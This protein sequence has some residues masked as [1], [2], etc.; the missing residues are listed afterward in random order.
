MGAAVHGFLIFGHALGLAYNARRVASGS[1]RNA[2]D[3]AVH[4]AAL[5]YSVRAAVHHL[6]WNESK[7]E[8]T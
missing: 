8:T 3:V 7:R 2:F 5:G 1:R 4:A 6:R